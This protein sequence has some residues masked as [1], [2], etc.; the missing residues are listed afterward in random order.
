MTDA[1]SIYK[2]IDV[3]IQVHA[4]NGIAILAN[5]NSAGDPI[6]DSDQIQQINESLKILPE[7]FSQEVVIGLW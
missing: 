5:H 1:V 7:R 2:R 4:T 6:T 3:S